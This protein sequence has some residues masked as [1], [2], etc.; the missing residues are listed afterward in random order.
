MDTPK[1]DLSA[2]AGKLNGTQGTEGI[3]PPPAPTPTEEVEPIKFQHYSC[4]RIAMNLITPQGGK[5]AFVKY[6]FITAD[7]D[8]ITFLD[9]EIKN[10]LREV[11]K[12]ELLTAEEADPMA[13][14]KKQ[15]FAEFQQQQA[16]IMKS[17]VHPGSTAKPGILSTTG[18]AELSADS[19][20]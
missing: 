5:I 18:I 2:L 4:S 14:L 8:L 19:G 7:E 15:H 20:T 1:L 10:G 16:D 9:S 6:A 3:D 17:A 12:G 13:V 11:T